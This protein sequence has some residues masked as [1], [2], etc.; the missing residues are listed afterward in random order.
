M[1][2]GILGPWLGYYQQRQDLFKQA[3]KKKTLEEARKAEE[4]AKTEIV[5]DHDE[6]GAE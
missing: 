1:L 4:K 6:Q 2:Y 5:K 3:A